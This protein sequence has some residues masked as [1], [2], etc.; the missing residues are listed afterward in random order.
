MGPFPGTLGVRQVAT[1]GPTREVMLEGKTRER[2]G[3]GK[4]E[5]EMQ[6]CQETEEEGRRE[7]A[8]AGGLVLQL[9]FWFDP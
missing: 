6:Q 4:V 5:G 1:F 9:G 7:M 8:V 3:R 2:S